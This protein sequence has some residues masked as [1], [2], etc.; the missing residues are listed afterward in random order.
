ME[1]FDS[2]NRLSPCGWRIWFGVTRLTSSLIGPPA[3]YSDLN[4][5]LR[6]DRRRAEEKAEEKGWGAPYPFPA[7]F[8]CLFLPPSI[9][10][11]SSRVRAFT[12]P[13]EWREAAER[14]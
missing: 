5:V 2:K 10:R 11:L 13:C 3:A 12:R 8:S 1:R 4:L 9:E 6:E 14:A 7:P